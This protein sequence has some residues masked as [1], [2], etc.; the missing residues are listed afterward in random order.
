VCVCLCVYTCVFASVR[1]H[2]HALQARAC[3]AQNRNLAQE[4]KKCDTMVFRALSYHV[5]NHM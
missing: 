1:A 2:M 3:I 5:G 4:E